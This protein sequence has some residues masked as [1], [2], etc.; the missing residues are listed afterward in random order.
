[1]LFHHR[2]SLLSIIM[3][4]WREGNKGGGGIIKKPKNA[5]KV[6]MNKIRKIIITHVQIFFFFFLA[7]LLLSYGQPSQRQSD[8][9][10]IFFFFVRLILLFTG[11]H[12]PTE[13]ADRVTKLDGRPILV[14]LG[15]SMPSPSTACFTI[16]FDATTSANAIYLRGTTLWARRSGL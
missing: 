6:V 15:G 1:M 2:N 9:F 16:R 12:S 3:L 13:V 11:T 4:F 10:T 7:V 5:H 14:T 8:V